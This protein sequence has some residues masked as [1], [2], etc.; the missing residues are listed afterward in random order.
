MRNGVGRY[1]DDSLGR[2]Y[3]TIGKCQVVVEEAAK[4]DCDVSVSEEEFL[5]GPAK[6]QEGTYGKTTG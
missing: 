4:G 1:A 6:K 3:D 5:S 2:D